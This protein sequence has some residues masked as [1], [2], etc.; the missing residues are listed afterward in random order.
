[1]IGHVVRVRVV[2]GDE[3]YYLDDRLRRLELGFRFIGP[4]PIPPTRRP[5]LPATTTTDDK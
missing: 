3:S 5:T 2:G 1:M 4:P